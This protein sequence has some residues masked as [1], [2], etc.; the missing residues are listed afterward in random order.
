MARLLPVL[1]THIPGGQVA[2]A[3]G[4]QN[5]WNLWWA[6]Q[7]ISQQQPLF[8]T[9]LLYHPDGANLHLHTLNAANGVLLAPLTALFGAVPAYNVAVFVGFALT[10]LAGY[11]LAWHITRHTAASFMAGLVLAFCPYH[12]TK[13]WDGQLELATTQWLVLYVLLLLRAT[14]PGAHWRH[15]L[16]A[17]AALALVGYT[18]LYYLIYAALFTVLLGLLWLPWRDS[19][20]AIGGYLLRVGVP[21]LVALLLLLPIVL[22][23]LAD[24]P[25]GVPRIK[26]YNRVDPILIHSANLYDVLLPSTLHPIWGGVAQELGSTWHPFASAWNVAPGYTVLALVTLACVTMWRYAWRW[27]VIVLVVWVLSLGP[28]LHIGATRTDIWLPYNLLLQIPGMGLARRPGHL[29]VLISIALVPLLA[30]GLGWL[31]TRP[32][33]QGLVL[34]AAATILLVFEYMPT[35]LPVQT[36]PV[37]SYYNTVQAAGGVVFDVPPGDGVA[38]PMVAQMEHGQPIMGGYLARTPAYDI[39]QYA[40]GIR[41]LWQVA[42]DPP[43]VLLNS[44]DTP[45]R[46]LDSYGIR[47]V[48]IHRDR[49]TDGQQDRIARV[50]QQVLPGAAP[51]YSDDDLLA[52][53]VP[54]FTPRPV[55]YFGAGWQAE[56]RG[57]G[58]HWRWMEGTGELVLHNAHATAVP[59]TVRLTAESYREGRTVQ[60]GWQG[61]PLYAWTFAVGNVPQ[62]TVLRLLLP[63]GEHTLYLTAPTTE[64]DG[65]RRPLS[66]ALLALQVD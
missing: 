62:Q 22:P 12:M 50:M 47:H 36:Q 18:A 33:G 57:G 38:A 16:L 60:F 48:L 34:A 1:G 28:L 27:L 10:G 13:V 15:S 9:P 31:F 4:W 35:P 3:D 11:A 25:D 46:V 52:Y 37:H 54:P 49:L 59:V 42:P 7:A 29:F 64:E 23:A 8:V 24:L 32:R 43:T 44:P 39:T 20:R 56:E 51:A 61:Q 21:S 19:L 41:Q 55:A 63:P 5:V 2:T 65:D 45:A 26:P 58:R 53:R 40:P 6:Q 14:A 17:G 30:L 66:I